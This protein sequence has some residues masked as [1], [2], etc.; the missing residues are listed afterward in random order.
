[1]LGAGA[2]NGN[3]HWTVSRSSNTLFTGR[4]D[5]FDDLE[6]SVRAAVQDFSRINQRRVVI[7]GLGGQGKGEVSF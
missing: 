4:K 3:V 5:I 7:S 1:M 6:R 2:E